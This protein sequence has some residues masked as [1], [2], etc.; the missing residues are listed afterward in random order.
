MSTKFLKRSDSSPWHEH[1]PTIV[2]SVKAVIRRRGNAAR[3][4]LRV[5][6]GAELLAMMCWHAGD[7]RE[8]VHRWL[9]PR[10]HALLSSLAGNAFSG[11][12]VGP[13]LIAACAF[14]MGEG[15]NGETDAPCN[16]TLGGHGNKDGYDSDDSVT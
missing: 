16:H 14:L 12:A 4:T 2:G 10:G 5:V 1:L 6:F 8:G 11:Y 13:L 15:T 9:T 7:F 3:P